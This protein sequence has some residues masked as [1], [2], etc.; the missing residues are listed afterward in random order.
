MRRPDTP[1]YRDPFGKPRRNAGPAPVSHAEYVC[2]CGPPD[3]PPAGAP[4]PHSTN[5][6]RRKRL[7][8]EPPPGAPLAPPC[9]G[10]FSSFKIHPS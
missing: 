5:R 8:P 2:L 1:F 10:F 7:Y 6:L 3:E 4:R 9:P